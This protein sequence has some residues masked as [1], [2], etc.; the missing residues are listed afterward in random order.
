VPPEF[1]CPIS[2][3]LMADP[4]ILPSGR[5]YE[6]ACLRACAELAFVPPGVEEP[7]GTDTLIPNTALK[8][9]IGTWCARTGRDLPARPSDEAAREAVMRVM[10]QAGAAKSVRTNRRPVAS[11]SNSYCS[12]ASISSYGS[13]SEITAAEDEVGGKPVKATTAQGGGDRTD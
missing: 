10:R 8:V 2:G 6:R 5:T 11:S 9:A 1:V 4:V 3:A 12:P 13:S 7:G